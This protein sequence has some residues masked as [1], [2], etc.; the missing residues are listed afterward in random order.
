[1]AEDY[2]PEDV[3]RRLYDAALEAA[4]K[5]ANSRWPRVAKLLAWFRS[6][7]DSRRRFAQAMD[8]A[9][10]H[11]TS[12]VAQRHA[13]VSPDLA[14]SSTLWTSP[15]LPEA[16]HGIVTSPGAYRQAEWNTLRTLF[17]NHIPQLRADPVLLETI[18][19]AFVASVATEV[20][21]LPEFRELYRFEFERRA[22]HSTVQLAEH[23]ARVSD[24]LKTGAALPPI[25]SL[26]TPT[27]LDD[28]AKASGDE[29]R[30]PLDWG[31]SS[32][33]RTVA[34]LSVQLFGRASCI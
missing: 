14:S 6:D 24:L 15:S 19:Q 32:F 30:T 26:V 13:L 2:V 33:S 5:L 31:C 34:S 12:T 20:S 18:L 4:G 3:K 10:A 1:M 22:A 7:A 11:F 27:H 23:F 17:A 29:E 21:L 9:C 8:R 16:L 28:P 25:T